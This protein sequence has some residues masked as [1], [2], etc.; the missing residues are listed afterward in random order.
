MT[1]LHDL[2]FY[3]S[4][5]A[6][7]GPLCNW[8][9]V[10]LAYFGMISLLIAVVIL[11]DSKAIFLSLATCLLGALMIIPAEHFRQSP[12]PVAIARAAAVQK[13]K[14]TRQQN[15]WMFY[16]QAALAGISMLVVGKSSTSRWWLT[17]T[18]IGSGLTGSVALWMQLREMQLLIEGM[19]PP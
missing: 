11:K 12:P 10:W 9:L 7:L 5:P 2:K 6:Y 1:L 8:G 13:T 14:R 3:L 16:A 18:L 4:E 17:G 19:P 15:Q